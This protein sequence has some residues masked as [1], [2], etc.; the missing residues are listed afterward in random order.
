MRRD[1]GESD[2]EA[3]VHDV[4]VLDDVFLAFDGHLAGVAYGALAAEAYVVVVLDYFGADE[5]FL[6][7]GVDDAGAAGCL[8]AAAECPGAHFVLAGGKECLEVQQLVGRTDQ[9]AYAALLKADFGEEFLALLEGVEF[10]DVTLG[11]GGDDE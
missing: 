6:E 1:G 3:E 7:V 4:A 8:A 10:G 5:A 2:V 9:T 11:G